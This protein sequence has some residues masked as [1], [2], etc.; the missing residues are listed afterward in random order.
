M[1]V[2]NCHFSNWLKLG[3]QW[4]IISRCAMY[5]TV[6]NYSEETKFKTYEL[7]LK[8]I[9]QHPTTGIHLEITRIV[10]G[11]VEKPII[12]TFRS[13]RRA[14]PRTWKIPNKQNT[15]DLINFLSSLVDFTK[16]PFFAKSHPMQKQ[17]VKELILFCQSLTLSTKQS[18]S[19]RPKTS[20]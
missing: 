14:Q 16:I 3:F 8:C 15:E 10:W 4:N 2:L 7:V 12:L 5:S 18:S 13:L 20:Y 6:R 17:L 11:E 1:N 9:W 19:K